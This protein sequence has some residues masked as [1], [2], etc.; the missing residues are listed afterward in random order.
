MYKN[1]SYEENIVFKAII[2]Q[3]NTWNL[4]GYL[5]NKNRI[6]LI[7]RIRIPLTVE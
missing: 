1:C 5:Y 2:E 4:Y 6:F 7:C 3:K